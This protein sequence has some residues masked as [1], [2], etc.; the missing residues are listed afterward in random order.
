MNPGASLD[1][2]L[3][4]QHLLSPWMGWRLR[5]LVLSTLLGCALVFVLA[6]WLTQQP[7]LPVKLRASAD[8]LVKLDAGTDPAWQSLDGQVVER[9]RVEPP[10]S[11][12]PPAWVDVPLELV[13]LQ[14]SGRWITD[15][16]LRARD[17]ALHQGMA[18]L[19]SDW[20][21]S[22]A[23]SL[24]GELVLRG[25]TAHTLTLQPQG[26]GGISPLFWIL[27][28]LA[29]VAH[30]VGAVV[31]LAN[32]QWRN[33][34]YWALAMSQSGQLLLMAVE[35]GLGL[36]TPAW[37]FVFETHA[38]IAL[39]LVC[40]AAMV[41]VAVLHPK[42]LAGGT[43]W[44]MAAWLA[45]A[46]LSWALGDLATA[47]QWWALQGSC[48]G[49]IGLAVVLMSVA[50]RRDPHPLILQVRRFVVIALLTWGLM[51]LAIWGGVSRPDM[52]LHLATYGVM[53]WHVF[54]TTLIVLSP[55]VARTRPVLMEFSLL[56]AS[57][58]VAAALDLLF[59]AV[60]SLGQ[61]TSMT[62]A[63]FFAFGAY[64]M[65]RRWLF[66][67]RP[68]HALPDM[69]RLFQGLYRVAREAEQRPGAL[70]EAL[71]QLMRELFNPLEIRLLHG[72]MEGTLLKGNGAVLV[73]PVPVLEPS[74]TPQLMAL[75]YANRGRRL[76]TQED[77]LLAERVLEQLH[78][79][80]RFDQA[81][82]QGRSEERLRIA[83]DLH[84]DIGAR[85]LT[86]MY[87]APNTEIEDYIRHTLQDLKTLTRGLAAPTHSL[88]EAAAEWKQDLSHRL[89]LAHCELDWQLSQDADVTLTMVQWSALTRILRELVSNA[90]SHARATQVQVVLSLQN[91]H[92][93][94]SVTDNGA[95]KTP[96]N[97]SHGLG[98]GGVRKRVKQLG[99]TVSWQEVE[100]RG[101]RCEVTVESLSRAGVQASH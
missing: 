37:L 87:Q 88:A 4:H 47:A 21:L 70:P 99:G 27:A 55:Y 63:L 79:V 35:A 56:A 7:R 24:R 75:T 77:A 26:W 10:A 92:L 25:G 29:L 86:L 83:Q 9:L 57:S 85:L 78:R 65:V 45:V 40:C 19:H 71:T 93:R 23:S 51:S 84:D 15:P 74:Q 22:G 50:Y 72:Q 42:T 67:R 46:A 41:Q 8:G 32:P 100:P 54:I 60:F 81:V 48:M 49:L 59:V 98:L 31:L 52:Q 76:F 11:G 6:H 20:R 13:L 58:T 16:D 43:G 44:A 12:S 33:L 5:A 101:I 66:M 36:F 14:P 82:E 3:H 53:T 96:A 94:L 1:D 62:L 91:D 28:L 68:T 34:A 17:L 89:R 39:D 61:T 95:G 73:V 90:I 80:V 30:G 2:V 69:V 97:W 18:Q 64:L 38:R